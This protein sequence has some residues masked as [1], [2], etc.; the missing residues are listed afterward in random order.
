[1]TIHEAFNQAKKNWIEHLDKVTY[2]DLK[3]GTPLNDVIRLINED[4]ESF[5]QL[6]RLESYFEK[7]VYAST[8]NISDPEEHSV[9]L[10][11]KEE[12]L[13]KDDAFAFHRMVRGG[14][15]VN[16]NNRSAYMHQIYIPE[17]IVREFSLV[18]GD[19]VTAEVKDRNYGIGY[20]TT[21]TGVLE[22][23]SPREESMP[24][25]EYSYLI[26]EKGAGD[27]L[28]ASRIATG[29]F[30]K[31]EDGDI[32]SFEIKDVEAKR[33][34]VEEGSIIDVAID[35]TTYYNCVTFNHGMNSSSPST[36]APK[37]KVKRE[38]ESDSTIFDGI[39]Y[40]LEALRGKSL[41]LFSDKKLF[42]RYE[43]VFENQLGMQLI[44]FGDDK[45]ISSMK[46]AISNLPDFAIACPCSSG[47][48]ASGT[49]R[50]SSIQYDVLHTF[51]QGDGPK[52]VL[53]SLVEL[54][55][56]MDAYAMSTEF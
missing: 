46:S 44:F 16:V 2:E 30:A 38:S 22:P 36:P 12:S 6:A 4:A 33:Y 9:A 31:N 51:A 29:G 27:S 32:L 10:P 18:T 24:R 41:V 43:H 15:L 11:E 21:I 53:I 40:D 48:K 14:Q 42:G 39:D 19:I 25:L 1:M 17:N 35:L 3:E 23:I 34:N 8:V 13:Y 56:R 20:N 37:K 26:V 7:N 45:D 54:A 52:Q 49:L 47:H 28:Y 55:E 50:E 5:N